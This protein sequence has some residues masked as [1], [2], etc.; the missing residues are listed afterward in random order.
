MSIVFPFSAKE[1]SYGDVTGS[2]PYKS[3]R[4][5][6]YI[7][8][9][10]DYD[11]NAILVEPMK[12]RQAQEIASTWSKLYERLTRHGHKTS[13]FIL[14]NEYSANLKRSFAKYVIAHQLVP[15]HMHLRNAAERAICT[16]KSHFLSGLATCIPDF[17]IS[18][19]D[20]LLPQAEMTLNH[21]CTARCNPNL[22]AYTYIY[23]L[24]D[25]N[26]VPLP[27]PRD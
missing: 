1:L 13:H 2:F 19:W 5:H 25:F 26:K 23:G 6:Q 7:Y 21:L 8:I 4:G 16:F 17:P 20:R 24:N 18:E 11:S 12:T 15:P 10:Y 27:P 3:S 9:L 22:S 14:N